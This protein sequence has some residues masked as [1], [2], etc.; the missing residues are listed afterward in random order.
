M[1]MLIFLIGFPS[2]IPAND[3]RDLPPHYQ[4]LLERLVRDGQD[5]DFLYPLFLD[6][7]TEPIR[8]RMNISLLTREIPEIYTKFLTFESILLAKNFLHQNL[9][10]L[11]EMERRFDVEKEVAVAI[12]LVE[13]KLGENIGKHRVIPTLAS[14]ALMNSTENLLRNY[15]TIWEM[16]PEV[17]YSWIE[18][19]A[20]RRA[21]WAYKELKTFLEIIRSEKMDP[22][23]VYGSIAGALGMPQFIPS[24]Y[25]AYAINKNSFKDWLYDAE[26]AILSIGNY[27]KSHGWKRGLPIHQQK[28]LL[29][30]YN[31]SDPYGETILQ[32]AQR[33]RN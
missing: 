23:E 19:L 7:R 13:S 14:M 10:T 4:A 16:S 8:H 15:S 3:S 6:P 24:S 17:P 20:T 32:I 11:K 1:L 29:W 21:N 18:H 25:M 5:K 31:R 22:L 9:V 27:L 33:I 26:A 12:L 2:A 28:K 30:H